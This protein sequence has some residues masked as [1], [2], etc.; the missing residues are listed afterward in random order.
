MENTTE[1]INSVAKSN[2]IIIGVISIMIHILTYYIAP[3]MLGSIM[4]GITIG[5]I[6]LGIYI[7]FTLDMRKKIGGYWTFKEALRG[8]F[9][10]A[11]IANLMVMIVV[12]FLFYKLL[13]PDALQKISGFV[14]PNIT[15]T[16]EKMGMNQD[17]IDEALVKV[18]QSLKSQ[19][20][21]DAM[22]FLKNFGMS[23][24][25]QFILSLIFAAIFK[26]NQ[27]VFAPIEE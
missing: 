20:D 12:S 26:K 18:S 14:I 11:F 8:I 4:F 7:Y 22:D 27:P 10:M 19:F 5:L 6:S 15:S 1:S 23:I 3:D 2:G 17:Q 13:E 21:G 25:V 24:L 16:Y 9:L